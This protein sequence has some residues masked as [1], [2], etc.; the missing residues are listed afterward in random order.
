MGCVY[1]TE[2]TIHR[3][4][5]SDVGDKG[6]S[7]RPVIDEIDV[8]ILKTLMKDPRT[9]LAEI[10]NDC[11]ISTNAIR[12]RF[13]R[14]KKTGVITGSTMIV[15]PKTLGY[16]GTAF[17]A[18]ST[19]INEEESVLEF[20]EEI[21]NIT[22]NHAQIGIHNIVSILF[23]KNIDELIKTVNMVKSNS[24]VS[25]V[26]TAISANTSVMN[27][28]ENLI[29][30]P[31]DGLSNA[32]ELLLKNETPLMSGFL[33]ANSNSAKE[34]INLSPELDNLDVAIIKRLAQDARTS[35]RKL[36]KKLGISTKTVIKRFERLE[37]DLMPHLTITLNLNKIGYTCNAIFCINVSEKSNPTEVFKELVRI[38]NVIMA[39]TCIG[40]ID[41]LA[42]SPF[43][44]FEQLFKLKQEIAKISGIK[45]MEILLERTYDSWPQNTFSKLL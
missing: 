37:N 9:S 5:S 10:A 4:S 26:D 40:Q 6:L 27:H 2:H 13:N 7:A 22:Q 38:P 12:M 25:R 35:F 17:M 8:W 29:I 39:T 24:H 45:Q 11:K 32:N 42:I 19:D 23:V 14:L 31:F 15:N 20:L 18:I 44:N 30:E 28:P 1:H 3:T 36:A 21:P 34:K 41:I 16:E 33:D 43:A